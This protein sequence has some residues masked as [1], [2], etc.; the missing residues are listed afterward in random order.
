MAEVEPLP[1]VTFPEMLRDVAA[2]HPD[3]EALV[4]GA[5]RLRFPEM[6]AEAE[7]L[8]RGLQSLG[9]VRGDRVAV[10]ASNDWRWVVT[11]WAIWE[12]G[13]VITPLS[14]RWK[15]A[16][17]AP[18]LAK[19][20]AKVLVAAS[21]AA[22]APLLPGLAAFCGRGRARPF[23]SLEALEGVVELAADSTL[24]PTELV[25]GLSFEALRQR[26]DTASSYDPSAV[27]PDALCQILFTSGTTGIPKGVQLHQRQLLQAYWD[28]SWFA[29]LR[30]GDRFMVIPPYSHGFGINGGI[31]SCAMRGTTNLPVPVFDPA[32][33]L[34]LIERER[35]SIMSGPPALFATLIDQVRFDQ[36]DT[37]SLHTALIGAAAVP[38]EIILRMQERIGISHVCNGYGL[39]EGSVVSMT[40]PDDSVDVVT[41]T[42]GRAMPG[43]EVRIVDDEGEEVPRGERGEV[44]LRSQG[45]MSGYFRDPDQTAEAMTEEGFLKT[46]DIGVMDPAGHI[47]VVDRKKDMYISGGFNAYPAEI[48][49]R[50]LE[51]E[52][53]AAVAVVGVPDERLGEVGHAFV[54]AARTERLDPQAIRDWAREHLANYKVPR[55]V[56]V[57][58]SLPL[59]P[60]GKVRKDVLRERALL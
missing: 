5:L 43:V 28:W 30:P 52:D 25:G 55:R 45:I 1:Y 11:A 9:I 6:L 54:V 23:E 44:W 38:T 31:L 24:A 27:T 12:L 10:W 50:L 41:T 32:A 22:G 33:A 58:E 53:I 29:A 16:E 39:I 20:E 35:I 34:E 49:N 3:Q 18:L 14:T 37:S 13:A 46:G 15:P 21:E 51:R 2:R 8:A 59:N 60:N 26:G 36:T 4:D 40:R 42:T 48:E 57:V 47:A 56:H 19:T 17:V 7:R